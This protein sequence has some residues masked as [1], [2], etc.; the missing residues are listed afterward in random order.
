MAY[1]LSNVGQDVGRQFSNTQLPT[2]D[3]ALAVALAEGM[4]ATLFDAH[5]EAAYSAS[6]SLPQIFKVSQVRGRVERL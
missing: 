6:R 1:A 2:C 5:S 3:K 4:A